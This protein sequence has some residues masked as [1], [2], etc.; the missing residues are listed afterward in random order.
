MTNYTYVLF[1]TIDFQGKHADEIIFLGSSAEPDLYYKTVYKR[2]K[3]KPI[4][5]S[6]KTRIIAIWKNLVKA[7]LNSFE[8]AALDNAFMKC[9]NY[10]YTLKNMT[11]CLKKVQS[12]DSYYKC[13]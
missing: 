13:I 9:E 3:V 5:V 7:E 8:E 4:I 1:L 11:L 10:S 2:Y 6:E 12:F